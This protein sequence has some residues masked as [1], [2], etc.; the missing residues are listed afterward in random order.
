[1]TCTTCTTGCD[2]DKTD[3]NM[4]PLLRLMNTLLQPLT[5]RQMA[6]MHVASMPMLSAVARSNPSQALPTT[7]ATSIPCPAAFATSAATEFSTY[8]PLPAAR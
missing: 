7:I 8:M 6:F 3:S 2:G 4:P 5:C 1:M